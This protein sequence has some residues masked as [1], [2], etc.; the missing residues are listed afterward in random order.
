MVQ[1]TVVLPQLQFIASRR[2]PFRA[3][4]ADPHGPDCSADHRD[5]PGAVRCQVV[6]DPF[7]DV[8]VQKTAEISQLQLINK[9]FN[10]PVLA[11]RLLPM[12]QAVLRTIGIPQLLVDNGVDAP[13][14]PVVQVSQVV[15]TQR[16]IPMVQTVQQTMEISQLQFVARWSMSLLSGSCRFSSADCEETAVIP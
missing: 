8:D 7:L 5:F 1:K 14:L 16:L 9:G 2:H 3:A 6:D 12:V 4:E 11:Q 15:M 10:I 13:V